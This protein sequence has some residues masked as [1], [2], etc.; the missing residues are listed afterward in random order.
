MERHKMSRKFVASYS[1]GK[2]S[3]LAIYKAIQQGM[4]PLA[5]ITT[6][7]TDR[8]RSWFHGIPEPVLKSIEESVGVPVWYINTCGD[9]YA[10]NFEKKLLMAKEQGAEACVFGDIDIKGHLKWCTERCE[11]AGLEA[12]FPLY[13]SSRQSVVY[14]FI[15]AGF[16]AHFT[17]VDTSRINGDILGKQLT[18]EALLEIEAQGADICGENGEYHT[19]VSNGPIFQ[20]PVEFVFGEK[21]TDDN[22]VILPFDV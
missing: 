5:L 19:F 7:N 22:R 8:K 14:E 15:E 6:Y 9:K 13:G 12:V 3:V 2:D 20:K 18:K 10:E 1:G 4:I 21:I 11:N 16:T 17:I